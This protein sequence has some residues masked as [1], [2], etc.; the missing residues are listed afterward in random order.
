M[1]IVLLTLVIACLLLLPEVRK[2]GMVTVLRGSGSA[3]N[4]SVAVPGAELTG[5]GVSHKALSQDPLIEQ[6]RVFQRPKTE[7]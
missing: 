5:H 2:H 7:R 4:L 1:T 6:S 3:L